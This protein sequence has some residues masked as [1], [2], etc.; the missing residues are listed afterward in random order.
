MGAPGAD[1]CDTV[2]VIRFA[3]MMTNHVH[4]LIFVPEAEELSDAEV[5]SRMRILYRDSRFAELRREWDERLE[6]QRMLT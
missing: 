6:D 3:G 2:A 5:L 4:I 1:P